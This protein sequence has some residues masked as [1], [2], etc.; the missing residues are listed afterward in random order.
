MKTGKR[1]NLAP[2]QF[3][4]FLK[5]CGQFFAIA[6]ILV[7]LGFSF[8]K[9][10][11][12]ETTYF[13]QID[14]DLCTFCGRCETDCVLPVSAVKCVHAKKLCGYC[15]LCGGYYRANV[16]ELNTAAENLIC[17]TGAIQRKFI[18]EPYF[19]YTI[20]E[21]LCIGCGKCAK[22]CN[23]FGNGSL[24]LQIKQE[25]CKNCN[26][27]HIARNC[28]AGAIKR[29]PVS[30][31][32]CIK[33]TFAKNRFP[34]P[35]FESGY[36]YPKQQL[37][38][39]NEALWSYIDIA[40]LL[41]LMGFVAW[42]VIKKQVRVPVILT[43]LV[44]VAYFGFFRHGC[45]CSI[46]AIQNVALAIVSHSYT[47]PF[48]VL[49]LFILPIIFTLFF[50]RVFCAGVCPIGALQELVNVKNYKLSKVVTGVLSIFP[51]I[52]LGFAV[53]FAVTNSRFII[54]H[55]D[56]FVGI[57]RLGGELPL[58]LFGI[59]LLI[60]SVFTGRPFCRFLCPYGAILS[61]F[62]RISFLQV[63]IT[64]KECINCQLCH[65]ACPV[66]AIRPPYENKV[67]EKRSVG[68]KRMLRYMIFLPLMVM[69]G[70]LLMSM[71]SNN[72]SRAN[73]EVQLYSMVL[74]N[75]TQPQ[76]IQSLELQAFYAQ[77]RTVEEL[78]TQVAEIK[79]EFRLWSGIVG[80]FIGLVIGL[81]LINLSTK[82]TRKLYEIEAAGCISC[83]R[84][85]KYCPQNI[86]K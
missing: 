15:D 77:E 40:I 41:L 32:Y 38:I 44:S 6:A 59:I 10:K 13:W 37:I 57:F 21:D 61:L 29:V 50:G 35:D 43:S 73:N 18:E 51:W 80:A 20:N 5:I 78:A 17:P 23:A 68:V 86:I 75:E 11:V 69:G 14:P 9:T 19:E 83:G 53:L 85:F 42:A 70:A 47:I 33:A 16:K 1:N 55:Y 84:C 27:C 52:Y 22:G 64:K 12:K 48:Y 63:K 39:P 31:A 26:E 34:K 28:P 54:C 58:I 72:L 7:L 67:K 65:N 2:E 66:D 49:L 79:K 45:V 46:G 24:Y 3:R 82:R 71:L 30:E 56:P 8:Q 36:V 62:S 74:K 76:T 81:T 25:L 4:K 60:F